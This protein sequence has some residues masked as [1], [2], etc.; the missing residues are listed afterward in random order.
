[1]IDPA[2]ITVSAL[3]LLWQLPPIVF[4]IAVLVA[5]FGVIREHRGQLGRREP[6]SRDR[7]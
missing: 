4:A 6:E 2:A 7:S 1:M 5:L 3:A